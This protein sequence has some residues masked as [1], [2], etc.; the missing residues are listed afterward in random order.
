MIAGAVGNFID[1]IRI[2]GV[3]DFLD[4]TVFGYDFPVFNV[5][6]MCLNIGV[7][8]FIIGVVFFDD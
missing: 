4:F 1:R 5:A 2:Q 3:V 6:D 7:V 8:L